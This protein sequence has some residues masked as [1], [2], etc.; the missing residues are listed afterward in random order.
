MRERRGRGEPGK[1]RLDGEKWSYYLA[2]TP[3]RVSSSPY[4]WI[5]KSQI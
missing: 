5:H 2:A 1:S 4:R 3:Q